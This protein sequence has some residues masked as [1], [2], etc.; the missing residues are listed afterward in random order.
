MFA[1]RTSPTQAYARVGAHTGVPDANPHQIILMLYEGALVCIAAANLRIQEGATAKKGEAI[2]MA[3]DI[4]I[5][6]LKASLDM[7]AGGE[8]AERLGAL[9]DYMTSRLLHANMH[10]D[11]AALDEVAQLLGIIKS[12]WEEIAQ[13]PAVLSVTRSAA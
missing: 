2:S 12:A 8:L 4:I 6:G 9:Y 7:K 10:N 11:T 3:M 13:D 5:H 1:S